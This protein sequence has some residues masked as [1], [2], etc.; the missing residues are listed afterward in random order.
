MNSIS[1]NYAL[2]I[3][4]PGRRGDVARGLFEE[5]CFAAKLS[6]SLFVS[7]HDCKSRQ[8]KITCGIS[9]LALIRFRNCEAF[10]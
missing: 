4:Q 2:V 3:H 1:P 8:C 7:P 6:I 5:D 9:N 10:P